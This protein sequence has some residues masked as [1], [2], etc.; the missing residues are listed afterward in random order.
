MTRVCDGVK[1]P[2]LKLRATRV[3]LCAW[4]MLNIIILHEIQ[5]EIVLLKLLLN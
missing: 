4:K 2:F 3:S 1:G 5:L